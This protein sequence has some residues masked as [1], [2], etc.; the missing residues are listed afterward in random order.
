[1]GIKRN[2]KNKLVR[3]WGINDVNYCVYKY[4]VINGKSRCVW[5]CPYYIKW[6]SILTRSFNL[7]YQGKYPTYIGCTV[8]EEWRYLSDFIKWVDSQ[9][10]RDWSTCEPDKDFLY[11]N[12]KHYSPETVV[13]IPKELNK[14]TNTRGNARGECMIGV[15]YTPYRGDKNSYTACCRNPFN[16]KSSSHV[17]L[18]STELEAH[19]AWQAKK[20]EYACKLAELQTDGRVASRLREMYLPDKDWKNA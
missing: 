13:F 14:F 3:G 4:E 11:E 19:K 16:P 15:I 8:A 18:F 1:M 10:N 17:G 12:N 7:K 6:C 2:K 9:P 20:H 5:V